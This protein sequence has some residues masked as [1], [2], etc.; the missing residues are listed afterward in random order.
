V[1][2]VNRNKIREKDC[3]QGTGKQCTLH[4]SRLPT[5]TVITHLSINSNIARD[6]IE[7]HAAMEVIFAQL[8]VMLL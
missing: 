6:L 8:Y 5:E 2:F 3:G 7:N 4:H 1:A